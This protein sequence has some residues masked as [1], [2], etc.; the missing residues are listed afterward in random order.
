MCIWKSNEACICLKWNLARGH[1]TK[2]EKTWW[3]LPGYLWY[4]FRCAIS[5]CYFITTKLATICKVFSP[6]RKW[7]DSLLE[8][9]IFSYLP[10]R[11]NAE[12][13]WTD[14]DKR[15]FR[16]YLWHTPLNAHEWPQFAIQLVEVKQSTAGFHVTLSFSI[17]KITNPF[18]VFVS[19]NRRPSKKLTFYII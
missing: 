1:L 6:E 3:Y 5:H 16:D 9:K 4:Q 2:Q 7:P 13:C 10:W 19:S 12:A 8:S 17:L 15:K 14:F 11:K 18:K